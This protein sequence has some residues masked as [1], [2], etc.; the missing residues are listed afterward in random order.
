MIP[1]PCAVPQSVSELHHFLS[2][3]KTWSGINKRENDELDTICTNETV[4]YES[5][6]SK[7]TS[8]QV[9]FETSFCQYRQAK[10]ESCYTN[11]QCYDAAKL[12]FEQTR[13]SVLSN[14]ESRKLEW[15]AIEKIQCYID[16][17]LN[18]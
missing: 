2:E 3:M 13:D 14:A 15:S 17:L 8:D 4:V 16:V 11:N 18:D 12:Q 9:Q 7:C 6:L 5:K 10:Y 1:C